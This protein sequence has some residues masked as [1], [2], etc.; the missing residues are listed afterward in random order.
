M[1]R[2]PTGAAGSNFPEPN[3]LGAWRNGPT[4]RVPDNSEVA[5]PTA[6]RAGQ[7]RTYRSGSAGEPGCLSAMTG[8][9]QHP[10]IGAP[11]PD[12]VAILVGHHAR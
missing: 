4:L 9:L 10:Q 6:G 3:F 1:A 11:R 2:D 12:C 5:N 7:S 8:T